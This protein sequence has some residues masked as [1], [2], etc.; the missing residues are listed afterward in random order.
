MPQ[1]ENTTLYIKCTEPKGPLEAHRISIRFENTSGVVT[2]TIFWEYTCGINCTFSVFFNLYISATVLALAVKDHSRGRHLGVESVK[3]GTGLWQD[4]W[5][6]KKACSG[7]KTGE[8]KCFQLLDSKESKANGTEIIIRHMAQL[9][10]KKIKKTANSLIYCV[11]HQKNQRMTSEIIEHLLGRSDNLCKGGA[12][13]HHQ[14]YSSKK[15]DKKGQNEKT[16]ALACLKETAAVET[17][18]FILRF[19]VFLEHH[20]A[21]FSYDWFPGLARTYSGFTA[22]WEHFTVGSCVM[23]I[24]TWIYSMRHVSALARE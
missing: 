22:W 24:R 1:Y 8:Q 7:Q 6:A 17:S 4:W 19:W 5:G 10:Y 20:F 16:C 11:L 12:L 9:E 13:V 21:I 23:Q 2:K 18:S 15:I 14:T 3:K